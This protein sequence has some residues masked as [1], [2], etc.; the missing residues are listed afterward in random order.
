MDR[1]DAMSVLVAVVE[2]GSFSAAGRKLDALLPTISRKVSELEAHLKT[3]LLIRTTR[4]LA[5]TDAGA[6]Y[7]AACKRILEQVGEA[8]RSAS[9]EYMAPRGDLVVT[10]PI[11]FGRLHVLPAVTEFLKNYPEID[12]RLLFSDRNV[13][14]IDDHVDLAVRI[15]A[16]ADSSMV[17]T[18]VGAVRWVVCVSP[19]YLAATGTP[20][21]PD[22]L[23]ALACI[24][25]GALVSSTSWSFTAMKA[26]TEHTVPVHSRLSVNTT[27]AAI[28]AAIAGVGGDARSVLSGRECGGGRQAQNRAGRLRA[29]TAPG[30]PGLSRAKSIAA[31]DPRFPRFRGAAH[32]RECCE[33]GCAGT[34]GT[35][36]VARS[37]CGVSAHR[38]KTRRRVHAVP[39]VPH[40]R[41]PMCG[42]RC[43]V[44][45]VTPG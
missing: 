3:Q 34:V 14:L 31:K 37:G 24:S 18:R 19:A 43:T 9:G 42:S 12:V 22:D 11:V 27:E 38:R 33:G 29:R 32:P 8:E 6:V 25:F 2:T 20:K 10:A 40:V 5:L 4:R 1:L 23:S 7:V 21:V 16:L 45:H 41:F 44:P 30:Q 17:A 35:G 36:R 13:H 39:A 28:C 26:R 15:G